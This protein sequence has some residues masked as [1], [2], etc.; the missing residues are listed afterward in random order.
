M[1]HTLKIPSGTIAVVVGFRNPDELTTNWDDYSHIPAQNMPNYA[2]NIILKI[3][4]GN[5]QFSVR[6]LGHNGSGVCKQLP[7]IIYS[8]E[9]PLSSI[10][11]A[12]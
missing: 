8:H 7:E 4:P 5:V 12:G 10:H 6:F 2:N 9:Q 11:G 3:G 1:A